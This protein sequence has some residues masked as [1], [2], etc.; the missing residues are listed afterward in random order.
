LQR[1][2]TSL[3][4][5]DLL[6]LQRTIGNRAVNEL[7]QRQEGQSQA[8]TAPPLEEGGQV[9]STLEKRIR[10]SQAGGNAL[11]AH[12]QRQV[13]PVVGADLR[14][15]KVHTD[16]NSVQLNRE[17]GAKAFTLG[18]HI[19]YGA[20]QSPSDLQLTAHEVVHT[21]QQGA[22]PL[23][24]RDYIDPTLTPVHV[25][26]SEDEVEDQDTEDRETEDRESGQMP[27]GELDTGSTNLGMGYFQGNTTNSTSSPRQSRRFSRRSFSLST[28]GNT[29][30]GTSN[31]LPRNYID[32]NAPSPR[33][34]SESSGSLPRVYS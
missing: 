19:Y 7:L 21:V 3:P 26:D 8:A 1:Q 5:S 14:K 34:R 25:S 32:S 28:S 11:P 15:V 13:E 9:T 12:V 20:G 33:T 22:S 4:A 23:V 6:Y 30:G 24:Q 17:L 16:L 29:F 27:E 10:Q 2:S 31:P 18:K